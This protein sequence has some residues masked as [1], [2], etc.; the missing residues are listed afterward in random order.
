[1]I[2]ILSS[3]LTPSALR[4]RGFHILS[5]LRKAHSEDKSRSA[6]QKA[7]DLEEAERLSAE[8]RLEEEN[9]G[10]EVD[11]ETGELKRS[12]GVVE[13]KGLRNDTLVRK[14]AVFINERKHFEVSLMRLGGRKRRGGGTHRV[15]VDR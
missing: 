1:V 9:G 12:Y 6:E 11:E 14:H 4:A 7:R 2:S 15:E 13:D 10:D 8:A 5:S 3:P